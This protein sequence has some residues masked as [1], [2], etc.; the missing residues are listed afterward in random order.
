MVAF[1]VN[2]LAVDQQAPPGPLQ[3]LVIRAGRVLRIAAT[4]QVAIA[5]A[6]ACPLARTRLCVAP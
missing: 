1:T 3:F 6:G 5:A 4:P 2:G